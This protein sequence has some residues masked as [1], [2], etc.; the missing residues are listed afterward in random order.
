M[1]LFPYFIIPLNAVVPL[2]Y[3]ARMKKKSENM[4]TKEVCELL[5]ISRSTLQRRID[6]KEIVPIDAPN[7]LLKRQVLRFAR[8]DIEKLIP[9]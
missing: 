3:N 6:D 5:N 1:P 7:P 4:T 9:K 2:C 8:A